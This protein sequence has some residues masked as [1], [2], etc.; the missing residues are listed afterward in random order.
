M[1][2]LNERRDPDGEIRGRMAHL[3]PQTHQKYIY[4]PGTL[5]Q[6]KQMP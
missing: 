5:A 4:M 3:P 6:A 2:V 1:I